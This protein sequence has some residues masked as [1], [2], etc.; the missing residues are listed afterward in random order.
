MATKKRGRKKGS[1]HRRRRARMHGVSPALAQTGMLLLGAAAGGILGTFV[2]QAVKGAFTS[3]PPAAIGIG[4]AAIGGILP[5]F[6][7]PSPLVMGAAA[8]FAAVGIVF[9][10][11]ES[12]ISLPG[13]AGVPMGLPNARPGYMNKAV[14]YAPGLLQQRQ[15]GSFSGNTRKAVA[16]ILYN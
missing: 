9:A 13:I 12:F 3:L 16:G 8:G 14:G 11:N 7:K 5:M 2:N 10:A 4:M 1:T 15:M 6:V